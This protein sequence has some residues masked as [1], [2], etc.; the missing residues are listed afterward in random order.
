[1]DVVCEMKW[2]LETFKYSARGHGGIRQREI[3]KLQ[4][5]SDY[6]PSSFFLTG[7]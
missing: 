3:F 5:F 2:V 1:M 4:L 7:N 6:F